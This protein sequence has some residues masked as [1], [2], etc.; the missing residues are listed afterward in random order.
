MSI[1]KKI[2]EGHQGKIRID[3]ILFI[4]EIRII[5]EAGRIAADD[6]VF[7]SN[8]FKMTYQGK[9]VTKRCRYETRGHWIQ[10]GGVILSRRYERVLHTGCAKGP[11]R[12]FQRDQG[13]CSN[14]GLPISCIFIEG[15]GITCDGPGGGYSGEDLN[16]LI[17]SACGCS[18]EKEEEKQEKKE[19]KK[20]Q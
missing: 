8:N 20:Y 4:Q 14:N 6:S 10:Y 7:F 5:N 13:R 17:F 2:V 15:E 19:L 16:S 11:D 3:P 9:V 18:S 12:R 1:A